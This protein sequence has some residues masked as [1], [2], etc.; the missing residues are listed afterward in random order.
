MD[1]RR[2]LKSLKSTLA[3]RCLPRMTSVPAFSC[4]IYPQDL[5]CL[6]NRMIRRQR[7]EKQTMTVSCSQ[8]ELRGWIFSITK[9]YLTLLKWNHD[10][11]LDVHR[12]PIGPSPIGPMV[13][14]RTMMLHAMGVL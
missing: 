11:G 2:N 7:L 8:S 6:E 3:L 14:Q 10:E 9:A 13:M 4:R 12:S 1:L 5:V